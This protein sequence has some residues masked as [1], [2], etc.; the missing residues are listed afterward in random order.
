MKV[1]VCRNEKCLT[2]WSSDPGACPACNAGWPCTEYKVW[3]VGGKPRTGR[4]ALE[5][6]LAHLNL[7]NI[8]VNTLTIAELRRAL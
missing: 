4:E 3:H 5:A 1:Y 8:D 2:N 6:A 7:D